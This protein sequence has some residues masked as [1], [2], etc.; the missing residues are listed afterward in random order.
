MYT[1]QYCILTT[2]EIH[3]IQDGHFICHFLLSVL[4]LV[5]ISL[6]L[7]VT[8]LLQQHTMSNYNQMAVQAGSFQDVIL[9]LGLPVRCVAAFLLKNRWK[10]FLFMF[11]EGLGGLK[12]RGW[13]GS[14]RL[15]QLSCT[16]ADHIWWRLW[17][18]LSI[19]I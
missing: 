19:Q 12:G 11:R 3:L 16:I 7:C 6:S 8:L 13:H 4:N 2:A 15:V 5:C 14:H 9:P 18:R 10:L 17:K 1:F